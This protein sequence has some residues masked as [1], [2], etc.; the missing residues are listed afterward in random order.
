[1]VALKETT[2]LEPTGERFLP[3]QMPR[4]IE[5]EH[6]HRYYLATLF[7]KNKV[8]LDIASG[9]GYGA[10]L[11]AQ[12]AAQVFGVDISEES[13]SHARSRYTRENLEFKQGSCSAI[14][15]ANHTIDLIVSF[16]TLEHHERHEEMMRECRR[17]LKPDG[18]LIISTPDKHEYSEIPNLINPFH[19]KELYPLEFKELLN[20]HFSNVVLHGQ[21]IC[22]GSFI[23][24]LNGCADRFT[25]IT[26]SLGNYVASPS[27]RS[28]IYVVALASDRPLSAFTASLLDDTEKFLVMH[29]QLLEDQ[30]RLNQ[31][32]AEL[33][34]AQI[35]I[36][37]VKSSFS[38][39]MTK[40]L[41]A[42]W[43]IPRR[44][45]TRLLGR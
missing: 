10:N 5:I 29:R 24:A 39:Q 3:G 44:F 6:L 40:P 7:A 19:V 14:P 17:V 30:M 31:V 42:L 15:I 37:R 16:E 1:M 8:V 20:K 27:I 32:L 18:V 25:T 23:V 35:E 9:E 4:D 12:V 2:V 13:V 41:R 36:K 26:E 21:R 33:A 34:V 11:M 45:A 43:N 22:Y 28:P 38:W